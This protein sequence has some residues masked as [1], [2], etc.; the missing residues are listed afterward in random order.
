MFNYALM[1]YNREQGIPIN[2]EE[3]ARL[4]KISADLGNVNSMFNFAFILEQGEG[5]EM[6]KVEAIKYYKLAADHGNVIAMNSYASMLKKG[7]GI[8][9][10]KK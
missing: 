8:K 3:S 10:K 2:K 5:I 1:L 6:N 9:K 4:F 7:S